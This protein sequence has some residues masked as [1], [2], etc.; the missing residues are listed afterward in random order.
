MKKLDYTLTSCEQRMPLL[1]T[2]LPVEISSMPSP[3]RHIFGNY[4]KGTQEWVNQSSTT[5]LHITKSHY[6]GLCERREEFNEAG[7]ERW[8]ETSSVHAY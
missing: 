1:L 4:R 8:S 5:T 6:G 2:P 7:V 3:N